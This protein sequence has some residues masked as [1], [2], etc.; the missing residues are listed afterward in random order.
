MPQRARDLPTPA[1]RAWAAL[2]DMTPCLQPGDFQGLGPGPTVSWRR[3][4]FIPLGGSEPCRGGGG[5]RLWN[6]LASPWRTRLPPAPVDQGLPAGS[7]CPGPS[8]RLQS[9]NENM[10]VMLPPRFRA[11]VW[12]QL[13]SLQS[14][15]H[16][17]PPRISRGPVKCS[18]QRPG[19]LPHRGI[20]LE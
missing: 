15:L 6:L 4:G 17:A 8:A 18:R 7:H 3:A 10:M 13:C 16:G 9:T 19:T 2:T 11:R 20:E 1:P 12:I 14:V 5:Q